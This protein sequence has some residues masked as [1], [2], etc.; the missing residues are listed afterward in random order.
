MALDRQRVAA[1]CLRMEISAGR[2]K[3]RVS[4]ARGLSHLTVAVTADEMET[5]AKDMEELTELAREA[6]K[7]MRAEELSNRPP[8]PIRISG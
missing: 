4:N 1:I 5:I 3:Q 2:L 6:H 8:T 7:L